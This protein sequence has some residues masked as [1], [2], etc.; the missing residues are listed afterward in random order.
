MSLDREEADTMLREVVLGERS[1]QD[2][3]WRQALA[4]FP[5]LRER[6]AALRSVQRDLDAL[7]DDAAAVARAAA[8]ASTPADRAAV[9]AVLQPQRHRT[10]GVLVAAALVAVALLAL[11]WPRGAPPSGPLG[12]GGQATVELVGGRYR[13]LHLEQLTGGA[14]YRLLLTIDGA[15]FAD[16]TFADH[17]IQ[18]PETWQTALIAANSASLQIFAGDAALPPIRIK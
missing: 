9:G 8:G 15:R 13:V 7:P 17:E 11:F 5:E 16:Q 2:P 10:A 6:V 18:L 12:T 14:R 4:A 1:E 3:V